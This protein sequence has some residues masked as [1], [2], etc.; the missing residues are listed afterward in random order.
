[1]MRMVAV[2]TTMLALTL[3]AVP[4]AS[5]QDQLVIGL[6]QY[7]S[8]LHPNIDS[9]ATKSYVLD[10][11]RR[12]ITAFDADWQLT[13]H[14]CMELPTFDNG[15]A[16]RV[17]GED[18][19]RET[20]RVTFTLHP[21]ATWG[22]GVPV[23]TRDVLF[24]YDVG[25]HPDSGVSNAE[26]Y[27]RILD[28][29]VHDDKT[30]TF[31]NDRVTFR[32]N[33]VR[34]F[35]LL[36]EHLERAVFEAD[37]AAYRNRTLFE[38]DPTN[39]GLYFGP[40]RIT[41][42]ER[43]SH[44]VLEQNPT[45]YGEAPHFRRVVVRAIENTAALEANLLSG[46][47]D[48]IAGETGITVD[49]A[50]ALERRH[51]DRFQ[52][53]YKPTL[54]Y[55]HIDLN[56]DNPILADRRVRHALIHA[57][58][59]EALTGQ[60]FDGRQPV[61]HTK[62]HPLD[63]VHTEDVPKY[64]E[65]LERA[66]ELLEE[67][68]WQIGPDG[69]RVNDDGEPLRLELM[70]TAGNRTRELVQQVL[71]S[72]WRRAGIDIRIRN[73]PARVF[74][75]QTLNRREFDSMAMFAWI[76]APEHLPRTTLHCEEIPGEDNGWAGQNYTGYCSPAMDALIDAIELELDEA[77]RERMWHELQRLYAEDLP[78]IPLY[79]RSEAH[80]W[81]LWLEGVEPTGHMDQSTLHIE[82]WRARPMQ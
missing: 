70:T 26:L 67:A 11:A 30:F 48:M 44:I 47:I 57:I 74:F 68:G 51:G 19:E 39:P 78:V 50:V 33:A 53:V 42:V 41:Q 9:M 2:A 13:C 37:P 79:F 20:V 66:A 35:R 75:G 73:E 29:E 60:L 24:T 45:W 15:L 55:E 4:P 71:Q 52:V 61:A 63:W 32:Y 7:P 10:M 81:P 46:D 25:S 1:M 80:V 16:E 77:E 5:A 40:L 72:Q 22:D 76:S 34:D 36:P 59:R 3:P 23:T 12:P 31:H 49:Q 65:D 21:D 8:T 28:I 69:V 54:F 56:L 6:S 58:D 82:R 62:V 18:G 14:L 43:G 17:P 38:S 27:R 64:G